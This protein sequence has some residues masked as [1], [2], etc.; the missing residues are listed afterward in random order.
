[1]GNWRVYWW[2]RLDK[3]ETKMYELISAL[4][5]WFVF[6]IWSTRGWSNIF[7]KMIFCALAM[8]GTLMA[9]VELEFLAH[10]T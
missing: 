5:L 8:W 4:S 7:I 1:M 10:L 6:G 2:G 9:C 3:G